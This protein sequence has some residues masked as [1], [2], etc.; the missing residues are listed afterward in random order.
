ME[1][2]SGVLGSREASVGVVVRRISPVCELAVK[3]SG[4][5]V[6]SVGGGTERAETIKTNSAVAKTADAILLIMTG[7]PL[8]LRV[9]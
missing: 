5:V 1:V 4:A 7:T 3:I 8:R 9:G 2:G 6:L